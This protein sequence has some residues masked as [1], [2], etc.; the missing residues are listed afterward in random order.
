VLAHKKPVLTIEDYYDQ[1]GTTIVNPVIANFINCIMWGEPNGFVDNE[2]VDTLK[3]T[4]T[5]KTTF[6]NV[7]WR[8]K[9]IPAV[10]SA[11]SSNTINQEPLFDSINVNQKI[12]SF[13]LKH[14][15]PFISP[16]INS[17]IAAGVTIDL[18]GRKRPLGTAPDL[19][20]YEDQ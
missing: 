12:F 17:G 7:L 15:A 1:G 11:N 8:M 13:H 18:L 20:C 9:T 6:R 3:A 16:A 10:I 19:G 2:I 4:S 5:S 14:A